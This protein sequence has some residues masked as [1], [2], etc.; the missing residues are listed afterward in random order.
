M[1]E[2]ADHDRFFETT[3]IVYS[4]PS[5]CRSSFCYEGVHARGRSRARPFP[6]PSSRR[7][8]LSGTVACRSSS[9]GYDQAGRAAA[10]ARAPSSIRTMPDPSARSKRPPRRY[11]SFT[12]FLHTFILRPGCVGRKNIHTQHVHTRRVTLHLLATHE[13]HTMPAQFHTP[14]RSM[15]KWLLHMPSA[16]RGRILGRCTAGEHR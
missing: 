16:R 9:R 15:R 14:A 1:S 4:F 12:A 2:A 10:I 8:R 6:R 13:H 7:T 3:T 5:L 11:L